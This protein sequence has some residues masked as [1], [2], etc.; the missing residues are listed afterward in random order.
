MKN[1]TNA[2]REG[3]RVSN[4]LRI[5]RN[6][7]T[8]EKRVIYAGK[9]VGWIRGKTYITKRNYED[10]YFRKFKGFAISRKVLDALVKEGV[11]TILIIFSDRNGEKLLRSHIKQWYEE[12]FDYLYILEDGSRDEQLVLSIYRME[13]VS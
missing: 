6:Y 13:E 2:M 9:R 3:I 12:G 5:V 7:E 10:H 8:Q 11:E 1:A 4:M